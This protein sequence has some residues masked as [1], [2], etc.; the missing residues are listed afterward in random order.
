MYPYLINEFWSHTIFMGR[1]QIR[2]WLDC[3]FVFLISGFQGQIS[4]SEIIDW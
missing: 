3:F 2:F 1:I 4:K